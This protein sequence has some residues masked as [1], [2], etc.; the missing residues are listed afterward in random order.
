M[1]RADFDALTPREL[2]AELKAAD[3][4]DAITRERFDALIKLL[5]SHF[6]LAHTLVHNANFKR[7]AKPEDY[8]LLAEPR[9]KPTNRQLAIDAKLRAQARE[10][11]AAQRRAQFTGQ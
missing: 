3:R 6:A 10:R 8:K 2:K 1:S 9:A 11:I 4:R 5:D 7:R